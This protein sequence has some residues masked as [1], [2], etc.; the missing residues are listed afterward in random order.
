MELTR[1]GF[2]GAAGTAGA[3]AITGSALQEAPA[4]AEAPGQGDGAEAAP[5]ATYTCDIC[6][7][8]AGNS[9]LSAAVE[10]AQQRAGN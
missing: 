8:G 6:I 4:F 10:A 1:R 3:M 2:F 9:G 7:V 5:V